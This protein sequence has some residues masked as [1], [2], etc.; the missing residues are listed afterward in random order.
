MFSFY[1][2]FFSLNCCN[3]G[4]A[5]IYVKVTAVAPRHVLYLVMGIS[6]NIFEIPSLKA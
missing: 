1:Y 2:C 3:N 6:C 5:E 4:D